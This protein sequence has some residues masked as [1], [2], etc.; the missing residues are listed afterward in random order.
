MKW[1]SLSFTAA[2]LASLGTAREASPQDLKQLSIEQ[3]M[4]ID[5]TLATRRPEP[6]AT[7]PT[8]ISVIT[9]DEIR[10]AGVTT[11]ADA[12]AL[13][14]GVH[15]ARF[16]N[17]TWS[18]TA[19]G[20]ASVTANKM[21][22][23]ID[24]RTVYS[25]LFTGVFWNAVDYA[26]EDIDR[27]EVIRGPGATLWGANAVNGVINVVTRSSRDTQGAF[28][29]AGS[30][31]EDPA[32]AELRYGGR[33][34]AATYRAYAKFVV[35]DAQRFSTGLSAGDR[36]SREQTGVRVDGG[37]EARGAWML[38]AD[39]FHSTDALADRPSG[40]FTLGSLHGTWSRALSARSHLQVAS[41][42]NHE[43]R[44]IP[45]QLTHRLKTVDL[46]AQQALTLTRHSIVWGG[47]FRVNTDS[48]EGFAAISFDP[49]NRS[50]PVSNVFV[51][52]EI[53]LV[54]RSVY[55]TAGGKYEHNAFS[56]GE[57]QPNV[58]A[59][60]LLPHQQTLW[61]SVARAVRRP[62]RFEDD[63]VVRLPNGVVALT[64]NKDFQAETVVA[65]E[66]GYRVQPA[67]ML[68]LDATAFHNAYDRLRSQEA[69]SGPLPIPVIVGNTQNASS[70]GLE[71]ALDVHPVA[72]WRTHA[73]YTFLDLMFSK[74]PGSRDIG[75]AATEANDPRHLV[76][77]RTSIDLPRGVEVDAR[78]RSVAALPLPR[79]PAY[80]EVTA[81][82]GWHA[83][84]HVDLSLA[85]D[86]LLH[87]HHAEFNPVAAGFEQFQ[88]S[89]RAVI[90]A[91]F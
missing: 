79:V 91:R 32:D 58:R 53:A 18:V 1:L 78:W 40:E 59:R 15:A 68:A 12:V 80:S 21:L 89:I 76:S 61:G 75:G 70:S 24:G 85:G 4:Q 82:L 7:A 90:T 56:G 14:D 66:I 26:L 42:F 77:V 17:G 81:R 28:A 39:L 6:V 31:N 13:A 35:R 62:T 10:R 52:D 51:Q 37:T 23:M 8:A 22:V 67:A 60:W 65:S 73:S 16:N 2:V 33:A 27:I 64:G 9:G 36:R 38:K 30:G 83:S 47:G 54:P 55:L 48:T 72:A 45:L 57:W 5:V 49:P 44:R 63:V 43:Y 34:G 86:D 19:R 3:L 50:Y 87:P 29:Q 88:R 69:P 46:D 20:F 25:P 11:L 71:L 41:Y 84:R 74:D